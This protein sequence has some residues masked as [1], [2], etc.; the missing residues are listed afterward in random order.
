[1]AIHPELRFSFPQ[2]RSLDTLLSDDMELLTKGIL[3]VSISQT[4][5]AFGI[6]GFGR[7]VL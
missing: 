6:C 4:D 2:L 3:S 1:M 5:P 7:P